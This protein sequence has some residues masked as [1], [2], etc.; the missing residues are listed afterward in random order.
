[1]NPIVLKNVPVHTTSQQIADLLSEEGVLV[2][3]A[4]NIVDFLNNSYSKTVVIQG[5]CWQDTEQAHHII[6][7]LHYNGETEIETRDGVFI[8]KIAEQEEKTI[9][10]PEEENNPDP[11]C[12]ELDA[13]FYLDLRDLDLRDL[14]EKELAQ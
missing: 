12:E 6:K 8:A 2:A 3:V 13:Y 5:H 4:S 14:I 7:N 11:K 10:E 9:A 1:M